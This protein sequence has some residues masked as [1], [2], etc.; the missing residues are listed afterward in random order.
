MQEHYEHVVLELLALATEC[1]LRNGAIEPAYPLWKVL[2]DNVMRAVLQSIEGVMSQSEL[3]GLADMAGER[4]VALV[5]SS[6]LGPAP[7]R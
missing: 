1:D 5:D 6:T 4:A 3:D 7:D 2:G